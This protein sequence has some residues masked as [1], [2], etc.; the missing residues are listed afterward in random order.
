MKKSNSA[1]RSRKDPLAL[2]DE[3][4]IQQLAAKAELLAEQRVE[5]GTASNDLLK[6]LI[7]RAER[8]RLL[9][10]EKLENE[11]SLLRAKTKAYENADRFEAIAADAMR[12]FRVYSGIEE[13]PND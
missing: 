2:T 9:K 5:D 11:N 3:A 8:S 13:E 10:E 7:E 1:D 12:M 6:Y 4:R